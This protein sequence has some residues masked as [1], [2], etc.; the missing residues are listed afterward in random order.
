MSVSDGSIQVAQI[1]RTLN[2]AL[3]S[4]SDAN[5]ERWFRHDINALRAVAASVVVLF[6]FHVAGFDGGYVGVDI[7]FVI[8]G[9]L[10]TQIIE[11]SIARGN[12]SILGFYAARVR[13]IVPALA[14][15]SLLL[16]LAGLAFIDPL[17]LA[18]IAR[19][20]VASVLFVSNILYASQSGYFADASETNWLLHTWTLSAEWQFYMIYPI[21][22]ASASRWAWLWR[23]RLTFLVIGCVIGLGERSGSPIKRPICV[24]MHSFCCQ[25]G[26]GKC[27]R[28]VC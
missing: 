24:I 2:S 3:G 9:L 4:A 22:L 14:V 23:H 13:R 5:N 26:R 27:S 20:A 25:Q 17:T 11:R 8:S 18:E 28:V 10:M 15:L 6:H 21:V 1:P 7:F 16:V 12:F 19:N